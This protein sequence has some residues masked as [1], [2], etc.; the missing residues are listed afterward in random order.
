LAG[1]RILTPF[2]FVGANLTIYW[3]GWHTVSRLLL[4][5]LAAFALLLVSRATGRRGHQRMDW[6]ASAWIAP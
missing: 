5:V 2:G 4:A 3:S 6:R 1:R